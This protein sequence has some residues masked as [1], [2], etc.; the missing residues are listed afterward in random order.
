MTVTAPKTRRFLQIITLAVAVGVSGGLFA[1][2]GEHAEAL[3][4]ADNAKWRNECASCH[5]LYHPALLPER[6]WRKMMSGLSQHFGENAKLDLVAQKE[7]TEFLAAHA[8]DLSS[9]HRAQKIAKSVPV[10]EV[11]LRVSE[12]AYIIHKH[13]EIRAE[14]WQ[15]KAIGSKANCAAC[16][17]EAEKGNFDKHKVRIPR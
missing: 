3:P 6:S 2:D 4:P 11:P 9:S 16:H 7:I 14:I 13:N 10:G 12:T 8:A 17:A 1:G 5:M 15:R